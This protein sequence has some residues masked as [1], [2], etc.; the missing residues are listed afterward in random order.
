MDI[1]KQ[2]VADRRVPLAALRDA[3]VVPDPPRAADEPA[4]GSRSVWGDSGPPAHTLEACLIP[5]STQLARTQVQDAQA[6]SDS[7]ALPFDTCHT[8]GKWSTGADE[9]EPTTCGPGSFRNGAKAKICTRAL[10]D[11]LHRCRRSGTLGMDTWISP[12]VVVDVCCGDCWWV[13]DWL[14]EVG[15]MVNYMGVD[16]SAFAVRQAFDLSNVG[17]GEGCHRHGVIQG[18]VA[19]NLFDP[20]HPWQSYPTH[21]LHFADVVVIKD[22]LQH[23]NYPICR[24]MLA[25]VGR[26]LKPGGRMLANSHS[27]RQVNEDRGAWCAPNDATS[28]QQYNL[29]AKPFHLL[30]ITPPGELLYKKPNGESTGVVADGGKNKKL[31]ERFYWFKPPLFA[32]EN[33][34]WQTWPRLAAECPRLRKGLSQS[35]STIPLNRPANP[36]PDR[37][38]HLLSWGAL[39]ASLRPPPPR[40]TNPRPKMRGVPLSRGALRAPLRKTRRGKTLP[41]LGARQLH[42]RR[43]LLTTPR[44]SPRRR[45]GPETDQR[46][47]QSR[48]LWVRTGQGESLAPQDPSISSP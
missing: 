11:E 7:R 3:W 43:V 20:R 36:G 23:S 29:E 28:W 21:T 48:R 27:G 25:F 19:Y 10:T 2:W 17:V 9:G 35:P 26:V 40:P 12:M 15:D 41:T 30:R 45:R 46:P 5:L 24:R 14:R 42:Q 47:L 32:D 39:R 38:E 13:S 22:I 6:D 37:K 8:G 44:R 33:H 16:I 18:D 1:A 34:P 31:H 4:A